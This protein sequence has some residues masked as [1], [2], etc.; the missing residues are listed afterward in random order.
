MN[1]VMSMGRRSNAK[2]WLTGSLKQE[3]WAAE[4]LLKKKILWDTGLANSA[5]RSTTSAIEY[6]K[7]LDESISD[8]KLLLQQASSAWRAQKSRKDNKQINISIS[9][10]AYK[11]VDSL[12][13]A[14]GSSIKAMIDFLITE[15]Q[16]KIEELERLKKV[17]LEYLQACKRI[18]EQEAKIEELETELSKLRKVNDDLKPSVSTAHEKEKSSTLQEKIISAQDEPTLHESPKTTN[19]KVDTNHSKRKASKTWQSPSSKSSKS[20]WQR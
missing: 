2:S 5:S 3:K 8:N 6:L 10:N 12:A 17:E 7:G 16:T 4:Y 15:S 1:G 9:K 20:Q 13:K 18:E 14:N 19:Q 11:I